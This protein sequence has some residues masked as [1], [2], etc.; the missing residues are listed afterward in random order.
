MKDVTEKPRE[1]ERL[2]SKVNFLRRNIELSESALLFIEQ[3]SKSGQLPD[4]FK[5]RIETTRSEWA[6]R[7]ESLN[8]ELEIVQ[9]QLQTRME[10]N[11]NFINNFGSTLT[12]FAKGRGLNIIMCCLTSSVKAIVTLPAIKSMN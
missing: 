8:Q 10:E 3:I 9:L 7:Y 4:T 12:E 2:R 1:I 11:T 6:T 5:S